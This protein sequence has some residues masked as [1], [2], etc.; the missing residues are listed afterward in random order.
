VDTVE[1]AVVFLRE[2]NAADY[3]LGRGFA[4]CPAAG[5]SFAKLFLL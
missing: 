3:V 1:L 2:L 5:N 4:L